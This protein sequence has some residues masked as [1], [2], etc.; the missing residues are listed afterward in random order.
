MSTG[1]AGGCK[2]FA[3][4]LIA[5]ASGLGMLPSVAAAASPSA[6]VTNFEDE[7]VSQYDIDGGGLLDLKSPATVATDRRP[8]SVAV[9]PDGTSVYVANV[10]VDTISPVHDR[11]RRQPGAEVSCDRGAGHWS[12]RNRGRS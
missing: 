11:R 12:I 8:I 5:I 1:A 4:A 2:R 6:Y 3:L 9:T 10:G 7:T